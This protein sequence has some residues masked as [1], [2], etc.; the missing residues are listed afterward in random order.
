M[1][2][3]GTRT[4]CKRCGGLGRYQNG[5]CKACA[6]AKSSARH[7]AMIAG[8]EA[9]SYRRKRSLR[10][11][12]TRYGL[13]PEAY[14]AMLAAQGGRCA[15]CGDAEPSHVDHSH[16]SN[17]VRGLLCFHCNVGLGSF[18]ESPERLSAAIRYV[19]ASRV[20]EVA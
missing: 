10:A 8:P 7:A 18:R 20:R 15:I 4:P 19:R 2:V 14:Y 1:P 12:L 16:A 3:K 5:T 11:R 17:V 9:A 6:I 13:T